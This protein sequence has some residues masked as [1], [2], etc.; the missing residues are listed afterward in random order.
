MAEERECLN[1][2]KKFIPICHITRQKYRSEACRYRY[3]NA[4]R[5]Y[6]VPVN[7]CSARGDTVE[8]KIA[9]RDDGGG[10]AE[11]SAG[12]RIFKINVEIITTGRAGGMHK[13]PWG[14][15]RAEPIGSS[16]GLPIAQISRACP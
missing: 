14:M 2:G 9:G 6:E 8:Q 13:P 3:N 15:S 11:I 1:C 10:S 7:I 4:K 16:K 5:H 12:W